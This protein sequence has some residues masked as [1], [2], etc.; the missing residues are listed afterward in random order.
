MFH[1]LSFIL[2]FLQLLLRS[3][4]AIEQFID[5]LNLQNNASSCQTGNFLANATNGSTVC[6]SCI[7]V[8]TSL[9]DPSD[10]YCLYFLTPT[11]QDYTGCTYCRSGMLGN[12]GNYSQEY[13]NL[14]V[15][16]PC[17][18]GCLSCT[19]STMCTLCYSGFGLVQL[20]TQGQ[21]IQYCMA[22]SSL[23]QL[24]LNQS[25]KQEIMNIFSFLLLIVCYMCF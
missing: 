8:C 14:S 16:V 12:Q 10:S 6:L 13:H 5:T 20:N 15:C 7:E 22:N 1:N 25:S 18:G 9:C 3:G 23:I 19:S 11:C 21:Y 24:V 17:T 2:V 4:F